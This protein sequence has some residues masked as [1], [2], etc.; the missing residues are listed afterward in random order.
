[1]SMDMCVDCDRLVDTDDDCDCYI[2]V[3]NMRKQTKTICVC[4]PCR[5]R[6]QMAAENEQTEPK[7]PISRSLLEFV[8]FGKGR[9]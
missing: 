9:A 1:M 7:E 2:E 8:M 6:R 5:E 4:E 3:G